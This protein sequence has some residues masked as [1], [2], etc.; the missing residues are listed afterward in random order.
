MCYINYF[1]R[2]RIPKKHVFYHKS[3]SHQGNYVLSFSFGFDREDEVFQFALAP[4]YSYSRYQ[5]FLSVLESKATYLNE[6][7]KRDLLGHS[8]VIILLIQ[9][10]NFILI[11]KSIVLSKTV[12]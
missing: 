2:Q 6:S 8:V 11:N 7:F 5:L 12:V 10:A 4:P 1:F 9:F 3:P